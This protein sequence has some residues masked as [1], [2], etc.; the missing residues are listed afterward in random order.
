M[1]G[2]TPLD[3]YADRKWIIGDVFIRAVSTVIFDI[4]NKQIGL[5]SK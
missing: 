5:A 1:S 4:D 2:F 3:G